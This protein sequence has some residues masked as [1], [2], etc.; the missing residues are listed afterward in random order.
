MGTLRKYSRNVRNDPEY[1][2]WKGLRARVLNPKHTSF[3]RYGGRGLSIDPLFDNYEVF[4]AELGRRPSAKH[5]VERKDN[6][7]GY[8]SGNLVWALPREQC[9]NTRRNKLITLEGVT[10]SLV[11]WCEIMNLP[12]STIRSRLSD[13]WGDTEALTTPIRIGNYKRK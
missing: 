1:V 3:H 12:Y 10:K 5:W 8:V 2:V 6:A 9:R 7:K 13:G 11:E 4:L